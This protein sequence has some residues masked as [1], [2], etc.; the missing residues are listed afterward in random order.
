MGG[1]LP[2]P[3]AGRARG[4]WPACRGASPGRLRAGPTRGN[5]VLESHPG[6]GPAPDCRG[7]KAPAAMLGPSP[8]ARMS[9]PERWAGGR[10]W[11]RRGERERERERVSARV[12]V[13]AILFCGAYSCPLLRS[14]RPPPHPPWKVGEG[15]GLCWSSSSEGVGL[16]RGCGHAAA[17]SGAML[18]GGGVRVGRANDR[19]AHHTHA[20]FPGLDTVHTRIALA[21]TRARAP[22]C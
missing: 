19:P 7:C 20:H 3:P 17:L 2:H 6:Q 13:R 14:R 8:P 12:R 11:R 4:A 5:L 22:A 21:R 16:Q 18:G 1:S 9:M 15:A 10:A